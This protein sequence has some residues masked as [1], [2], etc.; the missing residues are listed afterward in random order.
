MRKLSSRYTGSKREDSSLKKVTRHSSKR[1]SERRTMDFVA[2][3]IGGKYTRLWCINLAGEPRFAFV[4][5]SERKIKQRKNHN[6]MR[7]SSVLFRM[8]RGHRRAPVR[9]RES[10]A[11]DSRSTKSRL[12]RHVPLFEERHK[13]RVL[14]WIV[15]WHVIANH[16]GVSCQR[17]RF[18]SLWM[19]IQAVFRPGL[20]QVALPRRNDGR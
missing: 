14:L 17:N 9:H 1:K 13:D 19:H 8:C 2:G 18:R 16:R 15:P 11:P 6:S 5:A 20:A 10:P 3:C 12:P 4:E 7:I